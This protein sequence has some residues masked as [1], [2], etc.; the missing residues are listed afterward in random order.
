MLGERGGKSNSVTTNG[1]H[2]PRAT[3]VITR[4]AARYA[5]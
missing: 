4:L 2:P 5:G 3:V 1:R